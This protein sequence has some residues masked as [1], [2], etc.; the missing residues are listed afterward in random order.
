MSVRAAAVFLLVW[1]LFAITVAAAV[2]Q[3]VRLQG[4]FTVP[5]E[6]VLRLA[7]ITIGAEVSEGLLES[8]EERLMASDHFE[9][10]RVARRYRSLADAENLVL[11]I[12]VREKATVKSKFMVMP[13]LSASDEFGITYGA[14]LSALNLLGAN[15]RIS[16]PLSWGGLRQAAAEV[17][18]G[19]GLPLGTSLFS[20][21]GLARRKNPHFEIGDFR[22]EALSA[23]R[24]RLGPVSLE[25]RGGWTDVDFG[26]VNDTFLHYGPRLALDTRQDVSLPRDAVYVGLGWDRLALIGGKPDFTLYEVDLR[27][28]KALWG[29]AV[30]A[31]QVLYN[32]AS[33]HLPDYQRPFLGGASTLR[34]HEPGEY[35]GDNRIA[36]SVE[37]RLPLTSPLKIYH[38]G[39]DIFWDSGAVFDHGHSIGQA[40][41]KHGAGAGL[42]FLIAGFGLKVDLAHDLDDSIRLH[43]STGFRF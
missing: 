32:A 19:P 4:N 23:L 39:V 25:F 42:F 38:A 11:V 37:L 17:E 34:G 22:K 40:S 10:V 7:G 35:I 14:R 12:T 31:G 41:F 6:E 16:F 33:G 3:E 20:S 29:Q 26:Q 30:L 28:Y 1:V 5:D 8:I 43:F 21:A 15:E 24:R 9:A 36:S 27:G 2:I 18:F 13:I